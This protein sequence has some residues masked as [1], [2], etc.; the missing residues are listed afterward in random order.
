MVKNKETLVAVYPVIMTQQIFQQVSV[1]V[2][3]PK[4]RHIKIHYGAGAQEFILKKDASY[5][6]RLVQ[7][8]KQEG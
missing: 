3:D 4:L 6:M 1:E 2:L 7:V 8:T 5:V